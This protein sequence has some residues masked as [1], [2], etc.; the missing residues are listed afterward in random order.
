L[1]QACYYLAP[2]FSAAE[3]LL[4]VDEDLSSPGKV[5]LWITEE[6][7]GGAGLVEAIADRY[8][9]DPRRFY[10]LVELVLGLSDFEMADRELTRIIGLSQTAAPVASALAHVRHAVSNDEMTQ[11]SAELRTIFAMHDIVQS[12]SVLTSLN[13]RVLRKGTSEKTDHLLADLLGYWRAK[14]E[15]LGVEVDVRIFAYV[16]SKL[17]RFADRLHDVLNAISAGQTMTWLGEYGIL[18]GLLWPRGLV[19]RERVL[20][21][22]TPYGNS[23]TADPLLLRMTIENAIGTIDLSLSDWRN[24]VHEGLRRDGIVRIRAGAGQRDAVR[25]GILELITNPVE[26]GYLRF[27][28]CI[29][30]IEQQQESITAILHLKEAIQ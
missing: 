7:S 13:S 29:A 30:R 27:F 26:D 14:E 28:P 12:H 15:E 21:V 19:I 6:T 3:L 2:Q 25:A 24:R 20:D 5:T 10:L 16:A 18:Y 22:S 17:T 23:G 9:E 1:R 4:D 11:A 8:Q